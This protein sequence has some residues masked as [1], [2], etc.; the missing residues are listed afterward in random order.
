MNPSPRRIA[1]LLV[2]L[3][4]WWLAGAFEPA[5]AG[6]AELALDRAAVLELVEA[7]MPRRLSV[8][9]PAAGT[10]TLLPGEP[11]TLEFGEGVARTRIPFRI[12]ELEWDS[13]LD[14]TLVPRTDRATGVISLVARSAVASVE[15]L[16]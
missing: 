10:V 14:L 8:T 9:L 7:G 4:S 16:S 1:L 12:R 2:C 13:E 11:R 5:R 15:A 3:S 6:A